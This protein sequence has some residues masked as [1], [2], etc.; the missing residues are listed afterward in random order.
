MI[1]QSNLSINQINPFD[2][3]KLTVLACSAGVAATLLFL[4]IFFK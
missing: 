2:W 1:A 3:I 4:G